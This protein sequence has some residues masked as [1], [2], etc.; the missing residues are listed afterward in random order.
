MTIVATTVIVA[1]QTKA[2]KEKWKK[3]NFGEGFI[4]CA[5]LKKN[6]RNVEF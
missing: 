2:Q 6:L 4:F 5:V 3:E 1:E